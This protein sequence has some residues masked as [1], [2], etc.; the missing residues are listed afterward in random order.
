MWA[1]IDTDSQ[2][3]TMEQILIPRER[4]RILDEKRLKE[5]G[6]KLKCRVSISNSNEV[7]IAGEAYD[8]Y[9]AK[10]VIQA[11]GRGFPLNSAYKLLSESYFFKYIDLRDM[12]RNKEQIKRLK[13]RVIGEDGRCKEYIE[14]VSETE[15]SIYGDTIGII[16]TIHGIGIAVIGI[17]TLLGGGTHKKAYRLMEQARRK[18]EEEAG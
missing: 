2:R 10:N 8:E 14:S 7:T 1:V 6:K 4:A 16:G 5:I 9:N 11:F 17:E 3:L 13:A 18:S 15:L 12:F